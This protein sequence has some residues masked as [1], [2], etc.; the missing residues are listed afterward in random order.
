MTSAAIKTS[1][2]Y[3]ESEFDV[4]LP[5]KSLN[6]IQNLLRS[7]AISKNNYKKWRHHTV[8]KS[9]RQWRKTEFEQIAVVRRQT[10]TASHVR[11][12]SMRYSLLQ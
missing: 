2:S 9:A 6:I 7:R 10:A 8:K 1:C 11:S 4:L 5:Q 3:I 12:T